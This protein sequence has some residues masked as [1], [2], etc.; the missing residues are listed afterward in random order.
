[1]RAEW[2]AAAAAVL[3]NRN[4]SSFPGAW[5]DKSASTRSPCTV[6]RLV[7]VARVL[8]GGASKRSLVAPGALIVRARK[9][10]RVTKG[11]TSCYTGSMSQDEELELKYASLFP[12]LN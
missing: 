11:R 6:P 10:I 7:A 4:Q 3:W 2:P 5:I 8:F 1:M 9:K 12:H